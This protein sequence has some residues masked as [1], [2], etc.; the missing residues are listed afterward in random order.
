M[1]FAIA[2]G[3]FV[4]AGCS[5]PMTHASP[6]QTSERTIAD[7]DVEAEI[8]SLHRFFEAWFRGERAPDEAGFAP[9]PQALTEGFVFISPGGVESSRDALLDGL[10]GAHASWPSTDGIEI[11]NVRVR[12]RRADTLVATYE[13]WQTRGDET[14]GRLSTVVFDTTTT[15][16][17]RWL[18]VHETWLPAS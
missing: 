4:P 11:R 3:A 5:G 17:L 10:R 2:I 6:A 16:P 12:W 18:Q 14:K 1:P 8:V 15:P 9:L 7:A 13:E